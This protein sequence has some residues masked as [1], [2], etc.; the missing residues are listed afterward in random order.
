[1][2][3][4]R[5]R[6]CMPRGAMD[7]MRYDP[8]GCRLASERLPH[9]PALYPPSALRIGRQHQH[10]HQQLQ[11]P[12]SHPTSSTSIPSD[13]IA[14]Q[15]LLTFRASSFNSVTP[16]HN[17]STQIVCSVIMASPRSPHK[18]PS[19]AAP[20]PPH[21]RPPWKLSRASHRTYLEADFTRNPKPIPEVQADGDTFYYNPAFLEEW[22]VP[23]K[24]WVRLPT[25]LTDA[26]GNWQAAGAA[27]CTAQSRIDKL[28]SES[29]HRG[30]PMKT[31]A[32]LSRS[33]SASSSLQSPVSTGHRDLTSLPPLQ[34]SFGDISLD[35][36]SML[37]SAVETPPFTPKDSILGDEHIPDLASPAPI[38]NK[39]ALHL[40]QI[41]D[42]LASMARRSSEDS[43]DLMTM[44]SPSMTPL[45][46]FTTPISRRTSS[47]V[48]TTGYAQ[49]HFD[50]AAWDV[51]IN[52]YS[53][54][55]VHLRSEALVRFRHI[56]H[57]VDKVWF[58]LK[59][60]NAQPMHVG[61]ST[62][63]AKWWQDMM[64]KAADC[65]K[66]AQAMEIPNLE[67]I[68]AE[69]LSQGLPI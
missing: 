54:E 44:P 65:E 57:E 25:L 10:R 21:R 59:N 6:E 61:T 38:D 64:E 62:D 26:L 63:F 51:Y 32:H 4:A 58:D 5:Q 39:T 36:N 1:M 14:F 18:R 56:G 17:H 45:S 46:R 23:E 52:S 13:P 9:I 49:P 68:K 28:D 19:L 30:W 48:D 43:P 67:V 42:R 53:A 35:G 24:L 15:P 37:P 27:V 8:V 66:E 20:Q 34:T 41:N 47:A 69:R 33:M 3:F 16:F 55:L 22:T 7:V 2:L 11:S 12:Q 50:E 40:Q 60:D 31:H 29:L